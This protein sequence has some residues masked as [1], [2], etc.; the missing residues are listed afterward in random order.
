SRPHQQAQPGGHAV[1]PTVTL[2][3]ALADPALLGGVLAGETWRTWRCL[4]LSAMGEVLT[5]DERVIFTKLTGRAREPFRRGEELAAVVGRRGGKSRAVATLACYIAGLCGHDLVRGECGVL[6]C[7]APDQRQAGIVLGY[8]VAAF[9]QSPI[10]RQL[11]ANRSSDTLELTNGVSI[12]VRASSFRRL[13]GPTYVA[14]IADEAAFWYSDEFSANA[15]AEILNAVRP[16]LATTGGPL[17][18]ASSPY[19]KR[20]VLYETHK[21]HYGAG[22][23][24]L[25]EVRPPFSPESVV[26][27]FADLLNRYSVS[28]ITGDRYAGEWP[29]EQ[30]RKL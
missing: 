6:L 19:A 5:D 17:I 7:I 23:D 13:R 2:R 12:E 28:T 3:K 24:A 15:D 10:L 30:F 29:R 16:G 21:R 8:A 25:R 11:I 1:R 20:G 4:M 26:A 27:E 22:G 14:V 9:E 18:I